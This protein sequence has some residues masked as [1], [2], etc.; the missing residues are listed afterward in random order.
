LEG[1]APSLPFHHDWI[2]TYRALTRITRWLQQPGLDKL[3]PFVRAS[4]ARTLTEELTPD[5]QHA[6]V[7]MGLCTARGAA[8]WDA[9][10]EITLVAIRKARGP[11]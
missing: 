7:P 3:S 2:Q 10:I 1:G 4:Q 9:F 11:D 6:G 8:F 5:L